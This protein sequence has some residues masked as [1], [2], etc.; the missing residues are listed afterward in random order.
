[1]NILP[2]VLFFLGVVFLLLGWRWQSKPSEEAMTALKGLA[3]LKREILRVQDQ[4]QEHVLEEEMLRTNQNE[5]KEV[6]L[7][8]PNKAVDCLVESRETGKLF[9]LTPHDPRESSGGDEPRRNILPKYQEVLELAAQGQRVQEI[10][11]RLSLSQDAVRM[12]L[13][14][15]AKGGTL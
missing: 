12:V 7:M 8:E 15:Q 5:I 11:Q 6:E 4:V 1:M 3:Y 10:A 13:R 9:M 14:T 2:V